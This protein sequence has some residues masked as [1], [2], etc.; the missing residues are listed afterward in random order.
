MSSIGEKLKQIRIDWNY[1][2][3][4]YGE[5]SDFTGSGM[6]ESHLNLLMED[7]TKQSAFNCYKE[8]LHHIYENGYSTD[9][10]RGSKNTAFLPYYGNECDHELR[11]IGDRWLLPVPV[12]E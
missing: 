1:V 7:P 4:T 3:S 5:V 11:E 9:D 10:S 2:K 8:M 6:E 12:P